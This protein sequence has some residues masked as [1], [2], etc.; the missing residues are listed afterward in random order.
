MVYTPTR[1]DNSPYL[2]QYL[3]TATNG[4]VFV[5]FAINVNRYRLCCKKCEVIQTYGEEY[6]LPTMYEKEGLLDASIQKFAKE[7]RHEG[8]V[9]YKT[10]LS[11][12]KPP[13]RQEAVA[14]GLSKCPRRTHG[15]KFKP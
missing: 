7:H 6:A 13:P 10:T 8:W 5:E 15:R 4:N 1:R 2:T 9:S 3:N 14:V 12:V 11:V